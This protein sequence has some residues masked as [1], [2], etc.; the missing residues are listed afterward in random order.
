VVERIFDD[1]PRVSLLAHDRCADRSRIDVDGLRYSGGK[2]SGEENYG[3]AAQAARRC[4]GAEAA[5][6]R[7][8]ARDGASAI[9]VPEG[10]DRGGFVYGTVE[11]VRCRAEARRWWPASQAADVATAQYGIR[12]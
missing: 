6:E 4:S 1:A 3:F 11:T 2:R 5:V 9:N 7:V 8:A 12:A 10:V